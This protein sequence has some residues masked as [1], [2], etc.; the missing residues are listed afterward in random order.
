MRYRYRGFPTESVA[1]AQRVANKGAEY[2]GDFSHSALTL[3]STG[4]IF[5]MVGPSAA[6]KA[7]WRKKVARDANYP[8]TYESRQ[9][10]PTKAHKREKAKRKAKQRRILEALKNFVRKANPAATGVKATKV[11]GGWNIRTVKAT[12]GRR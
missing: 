10:N 11:K 5:K 9:K 2:L 6:A 8:N 3:R 7:R 1:E 4:K 12:R